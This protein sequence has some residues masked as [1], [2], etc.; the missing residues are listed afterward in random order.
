MSSNCNDI[1][2]VLNDPKCKSA[3]TDAY[4][5]YINRMNTYCSQSDYV[6]SNTN[7]NNFMENNEFI[8]NTDIHKTLSGSVQNL[9]AKNTNA[10]LNDI[11]IDK[12]KRKPDLLIQQELAQA[13]IAKQ[14]ELDRQAAIARQAELAKQAEI[15]R[16]AELDKQTEIDKKNKNI[17]IGVGSALLILICCI[18]Y[19]INKN[20]T[21]T[22]SMS[23]PAQYAP[24][25]TAQYA[26]VQTAQYAPVQTAQSPPVQI[27]Q[28]APVQTAQY[29]PVQTAQSPPVQIAQSPPVQIAQS[30]V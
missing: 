8:K 15:S 27:A 26:P 9:C 7:C 16:Q 18:L 22:P 4:N 28:Y 17:Y 20:K 23:S 29:A 3:Y 14:A 21:S 2:Q 30:P 24:V 19:F 13:A 1:T 11:C 25:Q 10:T 5:A 12:Y 6:I